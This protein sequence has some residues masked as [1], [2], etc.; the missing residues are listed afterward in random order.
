MT[1]KITVRLG[2]RSYSIYIGVCDAELEAIASG[3]SI[4]AVTDENVVKA[5]HFDNVLEHLSSADRIGA[6]TL[7]PGER[8]KT[9]ATVGDICSFAALNGFD[10]QSLFVAVSGGVGG[11]LTGFAASMFMRGVEFI[12]APTTLL[13]MVDSSVGGK[14]GC[15]LPCG[16]NLVG[17]FHQ[18]RAVFIDPGCLA[19]LPAKELRNG[20]A[21]V[22][23]YGMI[24]D[25][26]FFD[27][28]ESEGKNLLDGYDRELH[29][30]V[31]ERC[32]KLK[33][34][35]VADDEHE[36]GLRAILNF[37][38]TFGHAVEKLTRYRTAHG[39]A[40]SI[41]MALAGRFALERGE[42]TKGDFE[43]MIKLLQT[44]GLP[45]ALPANL[46]PEEVTAAMRNDKK[47]VNGVIRLILPTRIGEVKIVDDT[48][49]KRLAKFLKGCV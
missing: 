13:A 47:A 15:N 12:Q 28:L 14:T 20:L 3:R 16:K 37:G 35:V 21:E 2:R 22:I 43:R 29:T 5:G 25:G 38:H 34:Q 27:M 39:A 9:F 42:F 23:K 45:T 30:R 17:A 49:E 46:D 36:G 32:C 1:K 6:I 8:V 44:L 11:D 26:D 7:K 19:T 18:P 40:V 4:L 31:I 48:D 41:G 24:L 33:A 10:R